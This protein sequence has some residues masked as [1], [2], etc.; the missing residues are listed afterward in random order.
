MIRPTSKPVVGN[1]SENSNALATWAEIALSKYLCFYGGNF[2]DLWKVTQILALKRWKQATVQEGAVYVGYKST[3]GL[4]EP[5]GSTLVV[6]WGKKQ[7][8]QV[9]HNAKK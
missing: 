9:L 3:L 5:T 2:D 8:N 6:Q 7:L 4:M 1:R